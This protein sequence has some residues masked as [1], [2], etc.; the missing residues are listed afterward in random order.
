MA[1][2]IRLQRHGKKGKPFYYIVV[3]DS[4][5]P[6]DGKFIERLGSYN[7]NTNP[8]T[9][10]LN[11]DSAVKW[12]STGA[13]P[14]DTTKTI[15]SNEGVLYKNHLNGG[16]TK[17]A[18]TQEQADAKFSAW[19]ESKESKT[20]ATKDGLSSTKEAA[21][22][23]ALEAE[24]KKKEATAAAI[25]IKNTPPVEEVVEEEVTEEVVAE[26]ATEE[27]APVEEAAPAAETATEEPA[28]EEK[29]P[30]AE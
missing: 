16:I 17:G 26:V 13:T 27:A 4:R 3:A 8:A 2:K 10:V 24:T 30:S 5:S 25:A 22:K 21:K 28:A 29:T 11:F 1:T 6:R 15:L 23:L 20:Q 9:I 12:V 18:L 19:V 7:P 14:T